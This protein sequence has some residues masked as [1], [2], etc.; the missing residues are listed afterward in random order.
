MPE[1]MRHIRQRFP[2]A[3]SVEAQLLQIS[4]RNMDCRLQGEERKRRRRLYGRTK[5]KTC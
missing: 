2:W 4:A 1:W 5:P 3:P